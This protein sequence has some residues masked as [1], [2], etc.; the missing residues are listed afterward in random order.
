MIESIIICQHGKL[1]FTASL[2]FSDNTLDQD[3]SSNSHES[4]YKTI[5]YI[6]R[7]TK[8]QKRD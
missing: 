5:E 6:V 3:I 8:K 4:L 7:K 1:G 2:R